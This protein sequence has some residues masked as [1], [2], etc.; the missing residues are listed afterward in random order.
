MTDENVSKALEYLYRKGTG[1]LKQSNKLEVLKMISMENSELLSVFK[2]RN[3]SLLN[4]V[5]DRLSS[6]SYVIAE[7]IHDEVM[8]HK[9]YETSY[10]CSL[11]H[12]F[13]IQGM[14]LFCKPG[15]ECVS[16][17]KFR[18]QYLDISTA[19]LLNVIERK[20]A[21]AEID[22]VNRLDCKAGMPSVILIDQDSGILIGFQ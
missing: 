14:N 2:E 7:Y 18:D 1:E 13:I 17:K 8:E 12:V 19:P 20:C 11:D 15:K 4:L 9:G 3:L 10:R 21:D 16:C 6:L 5:L 22:G